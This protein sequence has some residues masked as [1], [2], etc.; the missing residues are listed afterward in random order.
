MLRAKGGDPAD[1]KLGPRRAR[2]LKT[3]TG[4]T[5]PFLSGGIK[6]SWPFA[7][8]GSAGGGPSSTRGPVLWITF[9]LKT[10]LKVTSPSAFS[11]SMAT[12]P[13]LIVP[14]ASLPPT[15]TVRLTNAYK[16]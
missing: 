5:L 3:G 12:D 10:E 14:S 13:G 7:M 6:Y 4:R 2:R 8:A 15:S 9:F 1:V 16:P 11:P